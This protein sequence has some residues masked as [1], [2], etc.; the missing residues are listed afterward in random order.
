MEFGIL[1][2][3]LEREFVCNNVEG[4]IYRNGCVKC[5]HI[6]TYEYFIFLNGDVL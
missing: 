6:V 2:G 3:C 5:V 4:I 1:V